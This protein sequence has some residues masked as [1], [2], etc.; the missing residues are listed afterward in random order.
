MSS[1]FH[2]TFHIILLFLFHITI[3]C[4]HFYLLLPFIFFH[5]SLLLPSI[6]LLWIAL[7]SS[8]IYHFYFLS[9]HSFITLSIFFLPFIFFHISLSCINYLISFISP[10]YLLPYH[11]SM[12][13]HFTLPY[14]S[15]IFLHITCFATINKTPKI[16][17][18]LMWTL[19]LN[20]IWF[21]WNVCDTLCMMS[22]YII[23]CSCIHCILFI[24][25]LF[26]ANKTYNTLPVHLSTMSFTAI[27]G[28]C[29]MLQCS[30]VIY[31]NRAVW[32]FSMKCIKADC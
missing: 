7:L 12:F 14:H 23:V 32:Y 21:H 8:C 17:A 15:S 2:I 18:Q 26:P 19:E 27:M 29:N 24:Y 25:L 30:C 11:P 4:H 5:I 10:F 28:L 6:S 3:S 1:F 31:F 22:T 20:I 9:Y 16:Y 13:L